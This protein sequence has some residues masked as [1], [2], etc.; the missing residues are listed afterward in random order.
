MLTMSEQLL[1]VLGLMV[2]VDAEDPAA[3]CLD[4]RGTQ[5]QLNDITWCVRLILSFLVEKTF[6]RRRKVS[7]VEKQLI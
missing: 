5:L 6:D 1:D 4:R 2:D 7:E 3:A